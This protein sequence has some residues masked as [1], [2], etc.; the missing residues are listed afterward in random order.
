MSKVCRSWKATIGNHCF[1]SKKPNNDRPIAK[2]PTKR[3]TTCKERGHILEEQLQNLNIDCWK[4]EMVVWN[5][6]D[7]KKA[8]LSRNERRRMM[9]KV[10]LDLD[11]RCGRM[12]RPLE[13]R[14]RQPL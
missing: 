4:R 13:M 6:S 14:K 8:A 2:S 5:R 12:Q 1:Q 9:K 7:W 10:L 3:R 11:I